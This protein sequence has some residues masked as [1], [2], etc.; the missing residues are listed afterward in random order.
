MK[1]RGKILV[2]LLTLT[3]VPLITS[4]LLQRHAMRR[5]GNHLAKSGQEFLIKKNREVLLNLAREFD[6]TLQQDRA[7]ARLAIA[8]Q[9]DQL[10]HLN[11]EGADPTIIYKRIRRLLPS[12]HTRHFTYYA[13][14]QREAF[15]A[16]AAPLETEENPWPFLKE[17]SERERWHLLPGTPQTPAAILITQ[18]I[19]GPQGANLGT[20]AIEIPLTSLFNEL[21]LP[22]LWTQGVETLVVTRVPKQPS[23]VK[24]LLSSRLVSPGSELPEPEKNNVIE[25]DNEADCQ[26]FLEALTAEEPAVLK[27][28]FHGVSTFWAF[29]PRE[30]RHPFALILLPVD[31]VTEQA[32][33]VAATV[34]DQFNQVLH[35][36]GILVGGILLLVPLVSI[37][38]ARSINRPLE[39]LVNGA[40]ELAKGEFST[41][42]QITSQ[43]EFQELGDAFNAVGPQ[44]EEHQRMQTG[45]LLAREIQL[46][47]LPQ[48]N[49][50]FPGLDLHGRTLS[51]DETGGD[52][53]DFIPLPNQKLA[54][55]LGDVTGHGIASAL[56]MATARGILRGLIET[57]RLVPGEILQHLNRQLCRDSDDDRFMTLFFGIIDVPNRTL[58]WASAGQGPIFHFA[59]HKGQL[60]ELPC[61]GMPLGIL[62][63]A[64]YA[65][66]DPFPLAEQDV[67][68]LGTDGLWE[69]ANPMGEMFGLDRLRD[70]IRSNASLPA[71]ALHAGLLKDCEQFCGPTLRRDDLTL[72]VVKVV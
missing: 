50:T 60:A 37:L 48:P 36:T 57:H 58:S 23:Q 32:R 63:A 68:V 51:C 1:F 44:L 7:L 27:M 72:A 4:L 14:G 30:S 62:E 3:L 56:L 54:V 22:D 34:Q 39:A 24:V 70:S 67:L 11:S 42:V 33:V 46:Q 5:L 16:D 20:T 53:Y 17:A 49:V 61:T 71:T 2:L 41:R 43:D 55:I 52:Y 19:P 40:R 26:R 25:P 8:H 18:A 15:P 38:A 69:T 65:S 31:T 66:V 64:D 28:N 10:S 35:H 9:A 13:T 29:L 45:L 59:S 21:K 6:E 12:L 47:L